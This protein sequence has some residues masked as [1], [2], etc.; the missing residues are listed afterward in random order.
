MFETGEPGS[1]NALDPMQIIRT[2][3]TRVDYEGPYLSKADE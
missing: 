3:G 2:I 1:A